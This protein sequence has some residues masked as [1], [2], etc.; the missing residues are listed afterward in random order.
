MKIIGL[1]FKSCDQ[2]ENPGWNKL[3]LIGLNESWDFRV[4][5][6][7]LKTNLVEGQLFFLLVKIY[8]WEDSGYRKPWYDRYYLK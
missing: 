1:R 5:W 4:S 6:G 7:L 3:L 8:F 2:G